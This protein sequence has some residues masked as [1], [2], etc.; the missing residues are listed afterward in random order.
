MY[1]YVCMYIC[2]N[3]YLIFDNK[4][5]TYVLRF[6]FIFRNGYQYLFYWLLPDELFT[7]TPW[8]YGGQLSKTEQEIQF[9]KEAF[10]S[11]KQV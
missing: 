11:F 9:T 1:A 3:D 7:E 10:T 4:S 8:T 5:K 2:S 6:Q